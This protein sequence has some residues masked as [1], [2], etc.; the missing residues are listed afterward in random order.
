MIRSNNAQKLAKMRVV[1]AWPFMRFAQREVTLKA[2]TERPTVLCQ[3][4]GCLITQRDMSTKEEEN[5]KDHLPCIWSHGMRTFSASWNCAKITVK[6]RIVHA[7]CF[8][9]CGFRTC[10]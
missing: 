6:E 8:S 1:L 9:D 3:C 10:L 5:A 7:I 4:C 2:P